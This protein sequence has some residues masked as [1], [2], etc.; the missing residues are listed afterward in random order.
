MIPLADI[1]QSTQE[2][3]D[4]AI[5]FHAYGKNAAGKY[6]EDDGRTVDYQQGSYNEWDIEIEDGRFHSRSVHKGFK[7]GTR[8]YLI[9]HRNGDDDSK[10][11]SL[12]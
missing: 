11:V 3:D 2:Y 5:T 9:S 6:F 12:S 10:S 8:Q 4:C 1:M 7:A